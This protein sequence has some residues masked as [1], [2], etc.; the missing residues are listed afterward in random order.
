MLDANIPGPVFCAMFLGCIPGLPFYAKYIARTRSR[1]PQLTEI[2]S[3]TPPPEQVLRMSRRNLNPVRDVLKPSPRPCPCVTHQR[4][5]CCNPG[6]DTIYCSRSSRIAMAIPVDLAL[7][8]SST[9]VHH[10]R[11]LTRFL[12]RTWWPCIHHGPKLAVVGASRANM[13]INNATK[14][15]QR[16]EPNRAVGP[17]RASQRATTDTA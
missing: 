9:L 6:H 14:G 11:W 12:C 4:N 1:A 7:G 8:S 3:R 2:N 10:S 17:A 5:S 16:V 13:P 15:V